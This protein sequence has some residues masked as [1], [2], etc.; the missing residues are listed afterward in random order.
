MFTTE[1]INKIG[2]RGTKAHSQQNGKTKQR[3]AEKSRQ[4]CGARTPP[5]GG[6]NIFYCALQKLHSDIEMAA[7]AS[8][9]RFV[10]LSGTKRCAAP[11]RKRSKSVFYSCIG[12]EL[13][14]SRK[15]SMDIDYEQRSNR[16]FNVSNSDVLLFIIVVVRRRCRRWLAEQR[17]AAELR[18]IPAAPSTALAPVHAC[19]SSAF[20][21]SVPVHRL[22][23]AFACTTAN[24]C[25]S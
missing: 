22:P 10:Y 14:G 24:D 23:L 21:A 17:I 6:R 3:H 11:W 19:L 8:S 15:R 16:K 20:I 4:K 2:L 12:Y 25:I 18:E 13:P 5:R 1:T 7:L 9:D